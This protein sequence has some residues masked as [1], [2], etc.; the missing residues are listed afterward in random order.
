MD[1]AMEAAL[2]HELRQAG[3]PGQG[4]LARLLALLRAAPDTHLSL[5]EVVRMAAE[6]GLA[7]SPFK[8][9]RHLETLAE[10]RL[11]SRLP[12]TA[13]E[14]VFDTVTEP[15]SHLIYEEPAQIVD[16]QVSPETLLAI[17]R[18]VLA[19]GPNE[20]EIL[21]RLRNPAPTAPTRAAVTRACRDSRKT[22]SG[23]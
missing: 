20:V 21:V 14:P 5:A 19:D 2:R 3:L 13:G 11:L 6:S 23:A 18:Q 8:L 15:H 17:L 4:E 10:H 22:A 16:L 7:A 12:S 1:R 9:A